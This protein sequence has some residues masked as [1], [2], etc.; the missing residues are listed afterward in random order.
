MVV[1]WKE[2]LRL[3]I[4]VCA[5]EHSVCGQLGQMRFD[6]LTT[7]DGL[8]NSQIHC[9]TQDSYG[10][11]W[12]GTDNGLN[13]YDGID[14]T[15][16][17][18]KQGDSTSLRGNTVNCIVEDKHGDILIGTSEGLHVYDQERNEFK[19]ISL[20]PNY[21]VVKHIMVDDDGGKWVSTEGKGIFY[22]KDRFD[23][24]RSIN[25]NAFP[26]L[27][28]NHTKLTMMDADGLVWI[29]T[30]DFG[31]LVYDPESGHIEPFRPLQ[32]A[33]PCQDIIEDSKQMIWFAT[34]GSGLYIY[35]KFKQEVTHYDRQT[36]PMLPDNRVQDIL[37]S[38]DGKIWM[39]TSGGLGVLDPGTQ[40]ITT[41]RPIEGDISSLNT[42]SIRNLFEDVQ[43]NLWI[44]TYSGGINVLANNKNKFN[45]IKSDLSRNHDMPSVI[46]VYED[47]YDSLWVGLDGQGLSLITEG[48]VLS[49]FISKKNP[50]SNLTSIFGVYRDSPEYLWLAAYNQGL[51][52]WKL[53]GTSAQQFLYD[54]TNSTSL[55]HN[56]V[57]SLLKDSYGNFWVLTNGGGLNLFDPKKGTFER[58]QCDNSLTNTTICS[59]YGLVLYESS[60]GFI[61][62]GTYGGLSRFN[63]NTRQ[64]YNY[65]HQ[66]QEPASLSYNWVFSIL[67]DR[68]KRL[69]VGTANGLN[70]LDKKND[71]FIQMYASDGL[72]DNVINSMVEDN[73]GH[74][75][76][77]TNNGLARLS[78]IQVNDKIHA[79]IKTY[80]VSDDL[81]SNEF[82]KNSAVLTR[83]GRVVFGGVSGINIFDPDEIKGNNYKP[84]V[85]ITQILVNNKPIAELSDYC[86]NGKVRFTEKLT[87]PVDQNALTFS[88][89]SL[90]YVVPEKNKFAYM[91]TG[92]DADWQQCGT[93][94]KA[95]YTQLAPGT[96]EFKVI[97]SNN[98]DV[99]NYKGHQILIEILP[100]IYSTWYAKVVYAVL[101]VLTLL[102]LR[103]YAIIKMRRKWSAVDLTDIHAYGLTSNNRNSLES[104]VLGDNDTIE[105]LVV[106]GNGAVCEQLEILSKHYIVHKVKDGIE[107]LQRIE[108]SLP[109]LVITEANALGINGIE[110]CKSLKAKMQTSHIPVVLLAHDSNLDTEVSAFQAGANAFIK[111]PFSAEALLSRIDSIIRN[112]K[113]LQKRFAIKDAT[114]EDTFNEQDEIFLKTLNQLIEAN[115]DNEHFQIEDVDRAFEMSRPI[116]IRKLKS[117][118]GMTVVEYVRNFRLD[119][120][121][122]FLQKDDL[123]ISQVAY[124]VGFNDPKYFSKAFKHKFGKLPSEFKR[125]NLSTVI[126]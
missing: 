82:I 89:T 46:S 121:V 32:D 115:L 64:F 53:D 74:L 27:R 54:E 63:P 104:I 62:I 72:P 103:Y 17:K 99:W 68:E 26:G 10:F 29:A 60:D 96:Y 5:V 41:Y 25:V 65:W 91:M 12:I 122:Q 102:V 88:F 109:D 94:R 52:K 86:A 81:Q 3:V 8:S 42:F 61:W 113:L 18:Y 39:A 77:S 51:T 57:R 75:W 35:N 97:A 2:Y 21:V 30:Q 19:Y 95:S 66:R 13:R 67:E 37:N 98:D 38:K 125:K 106:G 112:R 49:D 101:V 44:G 100:S 22:I 55:S 73:N 56:D 11:I 110:L 126:T 71:K 40:I 83:N 48:K 105:I 1:N 58:F 36:Q 69:W 76:L 24:I 70:V 6:H 20:L 107:G 45:S 47:K 78:N 123:N 92:V 116:L 124:S 114:S 14:F 79:D 4:C 93:S 90:N 119:K 120:S 80:D 16:F 9:I 87:L 15:V 43:G 59:D 84:P 31:V 108:Q 50:K 111:K 85:Y 7:N 28:T 118:T 34:E 117:M 33:S 23:T